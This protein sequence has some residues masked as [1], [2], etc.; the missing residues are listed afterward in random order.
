MVDAFSIADGRAAIFL[1]DQTHVKVAVLSKNQ[2]GIFKTRFCDV[3]SRV[4]NLSIHDARA[5]RLHQQ[6]PVHFFENLAG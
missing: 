6:K 3:V 4:S 1:N 5:P 2:N